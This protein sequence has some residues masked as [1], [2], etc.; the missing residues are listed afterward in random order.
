ME[1]S[2]RTNKFLRTFKIPEI[3]T[4]VF[5][6]TSERTNKFLRTFKIPEISTS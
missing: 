1:T 2:E 5:I 4:L 3:S 6:E